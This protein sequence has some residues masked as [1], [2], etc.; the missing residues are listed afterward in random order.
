VPDGSLVY[1]V[2]KGPTAGY[3]RDGTELWQVLAKVSK[4]NRTVEDVVFTFEKGEHAIKFKRDVN[5]TMKPTKLWDE[6]DE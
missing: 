6:E 1:F 4:D 2:T 3:T 5:Y